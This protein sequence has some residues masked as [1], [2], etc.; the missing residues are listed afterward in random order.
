MP[1]CFGIHLSTVAP[2]TALRFSS[3]VASMFPSLND[4]IHVWPMAATSPPTSRAT[5]VF[6]SSKLFF[7]AF[8]TAAA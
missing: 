5:F 7:E 2:N 6:L 4:A 3:S 1:S 8:L